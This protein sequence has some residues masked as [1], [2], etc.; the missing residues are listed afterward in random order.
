M[1]KLQPFFLF[2]EKGGVRQMHHKKPY[3]EL[4]KHEKIEIRKLVINHCANYDREYGCLPLECECYML[5]KAW[6]GAYCKYFAGAVLP[7]NPKLERMLTGGCTPQKK[8]CL[9]CHSSFYPKSNIQK[10]CTSHCSSQAQRENSRKRMKKMRRNRTRD[11]T[12]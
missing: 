6:A 11:V 4:T 12:M 5:H 1:I 7:L 10:Y 9:I 3:R 8:Q 2:A